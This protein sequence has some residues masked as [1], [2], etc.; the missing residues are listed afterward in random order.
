M[1][2]RL[3]RIRVSLKGRPVRAYAF[4]KDSITVG[5]DPGSDVFL[6]NPGIS[7][8]HCRIALHPS[9]SYAMEDLD[10]ANGV[11]V[12]DQQVKMH[13]IRNNDVLHVGKFALWFTYDEDRRGEQADAKRLAST[14]DEGTTVLRV[15]ELQEMIVSLR[16]AETATA[17]TA[18]T[19]SAATTAAATAATAAAGG[20]T[21]RTRSLVVLVV[22]LAFAGGYV[23]GGGL[24]WVPW[25][26]AL[27]RFHGAMS[28]LPH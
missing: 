7:R 22:L 24:S 14:Q 19:G 27:D 16:E 12:N 18:A 25:H 8:E 5:R 11:F 28:S 1:A 2:E 4:S 26:R 21:R 10:S 17:P 15:T 6:D 13:F 20:W 3:L 9:G 23:A